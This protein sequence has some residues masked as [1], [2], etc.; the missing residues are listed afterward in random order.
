MNNCV[1]IGTFVENPV[2]QKDNE[3]VAVTA[4]VLEV[5]DFR[6]DK[7]GS[8]R[9]FSDT[10]DFQA[11][12]TGAEVIVNSCKKGTLISV[13]CVARYDEQADFTYFRVKNFK[14]LN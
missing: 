6:K 8:K 1:F 4:F 3:G 12:H 5:D 10:L 11:W 9:K 14:I 7:G 13:E 2:L